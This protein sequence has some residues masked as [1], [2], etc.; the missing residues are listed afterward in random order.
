[1]KQFKKS[2]LFFHTIKTY[3]ASTFQIY[4]RKISYNHRTTEAGINTASV[5]RSDPGKINL[6]EMN[7]DRPAGQLVYPFVSKDGTQ[8]SFKTV[9]TSDYSTDYGYGDTITGSYALEAGLSSDRFAANQARPMITALQNALN[10]N[11]R[12]S[13]HYAYDQS[14]SLGNKAADELRLISIPSMFY[15]SSIKKGSVKCNF[16]VTGTLIATA[17]DIMQ[18]GELIQTYGSNGT[19]S[20]AGV[21][22]Y[23][24][25][26][27]IMT[28]AV[29][30]SGGETTQVYTPG[31]AAHGPRWIDYASTGSTGAGETLPN[32]VY[33]LEF[34]GVNPV[35]VL[36]MLCHADRGELNHSNN[37][38]YVSS[39]QGTKVEPVTSSKEYVEPDDL[40]IKNIVET[41]Y[42]DPT[43]SF[44][45]ITYIE[46]I[47]IWD[48]DK[49]L[50]GIAKLAK[51]VRK[52]EID[53]YTF[54]LKMDF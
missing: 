13:M 3:P 23:K 19:G 38:T 34:K 28:G 5:G 4:A 49:N 29:D 45:K 18:N 27:M 40:V 14:S 33:T 50:I 39:G 31:A 43:G 41:D 24:E 6:Y 35:P 42:A 36:T 2:D 7:V 26:F 47:S 30:L 21:V 37:P 46:K 15:G 54:K 17:R 48:K 44:E 16:Y 25:G 8:D 22:L 1:M 12:M 32:T 53:N 20:V 51:P 11:K 10:R 9:T 52:R